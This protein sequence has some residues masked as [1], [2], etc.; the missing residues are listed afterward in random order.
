MNATWVKSIRDQC[1]SQDVP[2][3]FKQWG[4]VRKAETGRMLDGHTYDE[5]PH[6]T[7]QPVP[8]DEERAMLCEKIRES[9]HSFGVSFLRSRRVRIL[10]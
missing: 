7:S 6:V 1:R 8:L 3:F 5:F 9:K 10:N 4:G 2:F